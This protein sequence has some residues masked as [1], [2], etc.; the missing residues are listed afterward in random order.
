MPRQTGPSMYRK[1]IYTKDDFDRDFPTDESCL[2]WLLKYLYPNGVQCKGCGTATKHVMLPSR[3]KAV[4]CVNCGTHVHP[5]AGTIFHKSRTKMRTWFHA[6]Y[7][8][9]TTRCGISAMQLMRE[10][11]V[12][13]KTAWRMFN[14]IRK[15]LGE[16]IWDLQGEVEADET[17]VGGRRKGR[18]NRGGRGKAVVAGAVER[19][20]RVVA[21]VIPNT[22]TPAILGP[23]KAHVL[24]ASLVFTDAALQYNRLS[25]EGYGHKRVNHLAKIYV[26]GK[27]IHTNTIEGFWSLLKRGISGVYHKVSAKHLQGY[28]NEYAFRYNHRGDETPMFASLL[29]QTSSE[30]ALANQPHLGDEMPS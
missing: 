4:S 10:T 12:T 30:V 29:S 18:Q 23:V 2:E 22:S 8:M 9:S 6:I 13:Y 27:D 24:P 15:L 28:V 14:Q 16:D 25:S 3:I 17:Y 11:K 20:G 1:L 5:T 26:M 21:K 7:L 19:R